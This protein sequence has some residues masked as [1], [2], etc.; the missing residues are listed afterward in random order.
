M[1]STANHS[2]FELDPANQQQQQRQPQHHHRQ[3]QQQQTQQQ[4][5]Q[6]QQSRAGMSDHRLLK[7]APHRQSGFKD[8]S[9]NAFAGVGSI[10]SDDGVNVCITPEHP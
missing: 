4:Q 10:P 9:S 3:Q 1:M 7:S 8:K 5:Q 2:L 6:Q